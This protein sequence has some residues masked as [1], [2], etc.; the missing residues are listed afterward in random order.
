[1]NSPLPQD[2][3]EIL[4]NRAVVFHQL[5]NVVD[6]EK[7]K[8]KAGLSGHMAR[9]SK[10][11]SHHPTTGRSLGTVSMSDP[12]PAAKVEDPEAF[13]AWIRGRY[14]DRLEKRLVFGPPEEVAAVLLQHAPHLVREV[15][16]I[17]KSLEKL[18]L[19]D[20]AELPVPGTVQYQPGGTVSVRAN[21]HAARL[22]RELMAG[23]FELLALEA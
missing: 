4:V 9:G 20:A 2:D 16:D 12:A 5:M 13:E 10:L 15:L 21:A 23:P 22:V 18:A 19:R 1:M 11:T 14:A 7:S 3:P 17:P 8:A 6:A